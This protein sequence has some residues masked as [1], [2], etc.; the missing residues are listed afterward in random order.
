MGN[1][2]P[3]TLIAALQDARLYDHPVVRFEVLETHISWVLLTGPYAYKIKKPVDFGFVDF[4]TLAK[5]CHYCWEELRLNRRLAPMLYRDVVAIGG[6]AQHPVLGAG[7]EAIEY[8]VRMRQFRQDD[9]LNRLAARNELGAPHIDD[10]AAQSAAFHQRIAVAEANAW[11]GAPAQIEHWV[12]QNFTQI[13]PLLSAP[14]DVAQLERLHAWTRSSAA[15]IGAHLHARHARGFIR[16]CHGDMHLGNMALFGGRVAI[17]DC[18]E[19]NEELRWIDVM[20]EVAF[21]VMDLHDRG[22]AALARRFLDRYLSHTGDYA[23]LAVLPYY[24]VYRALIRAKIDLLR[25]GQGTLSARQVDASWR[26]YHDYIDLA[27]AFTQPRKP[28]LLITRGLAGAGKSTV[29]AQLVEKLGLLRIRSDVERKRLHGLTAGADSHSGIGAGLYGGDA[30]RLTYQRLSELAEQSIVAG[31]AV[32]VDATFLQRWQRDAFHEL[33]K[34]LKVPFL[35][36]DLQ[37]PREVLSERITRRRRQH[38]DP[39][40][41]DLGVLEAQI[42]QQEPLAAEEMGHA[43]A[44]D[45]VAVEVDEL[46]NAIQGRVAR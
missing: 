5:R 15:Q 28:M 14:Q 12:E 31:Y 45:A 32:L 38:D 9:L 27:L 34:H 43:L 3:Q 16:E 2:D 8:A 36:L 37:A 42:N 30:T 46:V 24:L 33:A 29:A 13:A 20:S 39:S 11:F 6:S 17:F 21:V 35:I 10:I 25:L 19:F 4:T 44:I 41:A 22:H 7:G 26:E 23:G 40:E 18:L 1:H